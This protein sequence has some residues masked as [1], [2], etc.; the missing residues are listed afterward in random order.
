MKRFMIINFLLGGLVS[1]AIILYL[2]IGYM[3]VSLDGLSSGSISNKYPSW[4]VFI[5]WPF[6]LLRMY[7]KGNKDV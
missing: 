1:T 4:A 5:G 3:C 2:I 7:L 6:I